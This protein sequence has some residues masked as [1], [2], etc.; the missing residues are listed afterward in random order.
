MKANVI[1]NTILKNLKSRF[2]KNNKLN[3]ILCILISLLTAGLNIAIA[4]L[5]QQLIESISGSNT[6]FSMQ[7]IAITTAGLLTV[8]VLTLVAKCHIFPLFMRKAMKQYKDYAF[9]EITKKDISSF[10]ESSG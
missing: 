3:F 10:K 6:L 8:F 4:W 2:Y 9:G 1:K 5:I 7:G